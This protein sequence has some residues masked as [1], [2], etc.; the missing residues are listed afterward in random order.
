MKSRKGL[1]YSIEVI[2]AIFVLLTFAAGSFEVPPNQNWDNYQRQIAAQDITYTL[3][4]TGHM[5][6]FLQHADTGSIQTAV[7]TISDRDMEVSG[8]VHNL[9]IL[10]SR[11]GFHTLPKRRYTEPL[12]SLSGDRCEGDVEEIAP[13]SEYPVVTSDPA[14][15]LESLHRVRLY[16]ADTDPLVSGGWDGVRNYDSVWV[17]NGT[18]CQFGASE[19]PYYL[20][21]FFYWGNGTVDPAPDTHYDFKSIDTSSNEFTVYDADQVV[22]IRNTMAEEVNGISTDTTFD[23]FRVDQK[24]IT[25]YDV[26]VFRERDSLNAI[27]SQRSKIESFMR[28]GS[29]LLLMNPTRP[30]VESGFLRDVGFEWVDLDITGG[31]QNTP[32]GGSFSEL[33]HSSDTETYFLGQNGNPSTVSLT[34]GSKIASNMSSTI[35]SRRTLFHSDVLFYDRNGW[36]ATNMNLVDTGPPVGAPSSSCSNY[37]DGM[38]SF[39]DNNYYVLNTELGSCTDVFGLSIDK[40]ADGD[41]GDLGEGPFLNGE[42]VNV[43]NRE[44]TVRIYSAKAGCADGK[45]C[46]EF[47]FTGSSRV[48]LANYRTQFNGFRGERL[49]RMAYE[50]SYST[51]DRKMIA[52]VLY[53]LR[54]DQRGFES[55][56]DTTPISTSVIGSIDNNIFMPYKVNLRWTD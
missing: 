13:N 55:R 37:A 10:E 28:D 53:W 8:S 23:T 9:P 5:A 21:E 41:V 50:P 51:G 25:V 29:V 45:R 43:D 2:A 15:T 17:D 24:D 3:E 39:P 22:E 46:A 34:A 1:G 19:G 7:T 6:S 35:A 32:S 11:I 52:S 33:S 40:N 20:D 14:G 31:D 16:F 44:Y 38:F 26:I 49:A 12:K 30:Q 56:D 42:V 36:N 48:E 18:E 4:N 54:G 47:V 27:D